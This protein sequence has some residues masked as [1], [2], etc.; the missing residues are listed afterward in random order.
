MSQTNRIAVVRRLFTSVR[1]PIPQIVGLFMAAAII[2]AMVLPASAASISWDAGGSSTNLYW[3]NGANWNPDGVPGSADDLTFSTAGSNATVGAITNEV[4]ANATVNTLWYNQDLNSLSQPIYQTTMI[5]PG[6]TL[7]ISGSLA[8]PA[9][10]PDGSYSGFQGNISLLVGNYN[11]AGTTVVS[12]TVIKGG[13]TLDISSAGG[14]NT[15][16]DIMVRQTANTQGA[17]NAILDL[18]GLATFNANID[19]LLVGYSGANNQ[20]PNSTQRPVGTLYLAQSNTI[21]MNNTGT[22]TTAGLVIGYSTGNTAVTSAN[23]YGSYLYLGQTNILNVDNVTIGGRKGGGTLAYNPAFT[24]ASLTMRGHTG[25]SRVALIAI[26][27]NT[28]NGTSSTSPFGTMDLTGVQADIQ[29][30]SIILGRTPSGATSSTTTS[31]TGTLTFNKGTIDVTGMTVAHPGASSGCP[32]VGTVNVSGTGNLLFGS[33]GLILGQFAG[34]TG[35]ATGTL[36]INGGTV[37]TQAGSLGADITDGGGTS[38]INMT[39]GTIDMQGHNIGAPSAPIDTF[40]LRGGNIANLGNLSV[41]N[42]TAAGNVS[43]PSGTLTIG[44]GGKIDMRDGTANTLSAA[45]LTLSGAS[46]LYL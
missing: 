27:D 30:T 13:G 11:A 18:S 20:A 32:A 14:G 26:G 2:S 1:Q 44:S 21:T 45:N 31:A 16:G 33:S 7:K 17:H 22:T 28:N 35:S 10:L 43:L 25:L 41:N 6:Q 46:T 37:S 36:N 12:Q 38:T 4:T 19:Q 42:F 5:D 23:L 9:T 8:E 39:G 15:G 24:N 34:G 29:A 40:S 3:S